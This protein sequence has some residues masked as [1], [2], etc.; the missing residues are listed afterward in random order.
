[1]QGGASGLQP[2]T[3]RAATFYQQASEAHGSGEAQYKL[4]FLYGGNYGSAMGGLEGEG[5][6][7]SVCPDSQIVALCA[8]SPFLSQALLHYTFAALSGH[9]PASMT[10]GYRHWAGIG[11]KPS[12][13]AALPWYKAAA[14]AAVRSFNSGP[15]GGRHLPPPKIR[16]SDL[17]DGPYGPGASSSRGSLSTG[18]STAQ[19]QQEWDDLVEYHLFHAEHGDVSYQY[20]LGRLYYQGFGAR[21]L[22]GARGA[23]RGRLQPTRLGAGPSDGLWDGGRDFYRASKWFTRIARRLWPSDPREATWDPAWGPVGSGANRAQGKA[24]AAAAAARGAGARTPAAAGP[25]PRIGYFDPTKDRKNDKLD[26]HSTMVAGL[27]A[28]Y[29]GRMYLRGEG[30]PVNYAKAFL[31]FSRGQKQV[32]PPIWDQNETPETDWV[33]GL[34]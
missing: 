20:R 21:G 13:K 33:G 11:T 23:M 12:C 34:S 31:W 28:G 3:Q 5:H 19:T 6:Q 18:G 17:D 25:G 14:A 26:P 16:L 27:A 30:L 8:R 2:D 7:G 1:M 29:L 4:G 22:G 9:V 15:P 24:T 32:C 10:V